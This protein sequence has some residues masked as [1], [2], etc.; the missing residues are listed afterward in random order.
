MPV[1]R[2]SNLKK[3]H[4]NEI[5][6]GSDARELRSDSGAR[7]SEREAKKGLSET[8]VRGA[9]MLFYFGLVVTLFLFTSP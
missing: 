4:E 9:R 2:S 5:L 6:G 7:A 3:R 1:E 8:S